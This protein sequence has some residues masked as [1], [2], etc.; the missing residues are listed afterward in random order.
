MVKVGVLS[1]KSAPTLLPGDQNLDDPP[2]C[3]DDD[4]RGDDEYLVDQRGWL[5][6]S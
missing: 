3:H 5:L 4:D 2:E 6:A 1:E